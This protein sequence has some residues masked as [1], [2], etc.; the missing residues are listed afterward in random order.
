MITDNQTNY[1]YLADS[2]QKMYP[3]FYQGFVKVLMDC[4]I[5]YSLLPGTKDVW[6]VDYMPIQVTAD[7]YVQFVYNP[8]YLQSIKGQKSISDVNSICE[9]IGVSPKKSAIVI[10][11]GNVIRT[12]D[13]VIMCDKV[14]TENPHIPEKQ[15]IK[16]LREL[17][18]VDKLIF[19]PTDPTDKIG[20]ADG[21]VRF[22]DNNTVLI[23]DYSQEKPR[24]QL[25]FRMSLQNAGLDYIEIPYNPYI[26]QKLLQANGIYINYLQMKDVVIVPTF[27]IK[28]DEIVINRFEQLFSESK[29]ATVESNEI[30]NQGGIL[31]C[32]TYNIWREH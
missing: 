12:R 22:L 7:Q 4:G 20:H 29:I 1:L 17:F 8:N 11:G 23:N 16:E 32:I 18:Q 27:G 24:F 5:N 9:S 13:K 25:T 30:A 19:I 28:E 6:A 15:L 3:A 14:F 10:D 21:M 26:N 31:N 2:L